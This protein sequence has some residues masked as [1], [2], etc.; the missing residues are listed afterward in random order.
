MRRISTDTRLEQLT[1]DIQLFEIF[2]QNFIQDNAGNA[3]PDLYGAQ[4]FQLYGKEIVF[5]RT[6][7]TS[8]NSLNYFTDGTCSD[9]YFIVEGYLKH[10]NE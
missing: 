8:V 3:L 10:I 7:E 2:Y 6:V 4:R 5:W 1:V 9:E